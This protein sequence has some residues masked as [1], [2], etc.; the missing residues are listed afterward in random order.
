M[1]KSFIIDGNNLLHAVRI[2]GPQRTP[3]REKLLRI[4]ERWAI[5]AGG[6]VTLVFDG[7]TPRGGFREQMNSSRIQV[8]FS[9]SRTA[10]D[11]ITERLTQL[12]RGEKASVISDDTA[13][14]YEARRNSCQVISTTAFIALLFPQKPAT[15]TTQPAGEEGESTRLSAEERDNW[16]ELFDDGRTEP[17]DGFDAMQPET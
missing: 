17:F 9:E 16:L 11:C 7:S 13:I 6:D 4:I 14:Q 5:D 1:S 12:P 3:G 2:L 10:D 8:L 15:P